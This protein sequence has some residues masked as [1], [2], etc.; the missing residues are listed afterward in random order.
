M[1]Y[2]S[3]LYEDFFYTNI[4]SGLTAE[5]M[6]FANYLTAAVISAEMMDFCNFI[7]MTLSA[8]MMDTLGVAIIIEGYDLSTGQKKFVSPADNVL[9][10][11]GS[12]LSGTG[13]T[14]ATGLGG[15]TGL[16]G[17]QGSTG[18]TGSTGLQGITGFSVIGSTGNQGIT[19]F[20]PQG[21]TG[22]QGAT[23]II[24]ITGFVGVTGI[25]Q[26][27]ATG[28]QGTTG[29]IGITGIAPAGPDGLQGETG[30]LDGT[31]TGVQ[32][33]TGIAPAGLSPQGATGVVQGATGVQGNTGI[34]PRGVAGPAQTLSAQ[35]QASGTSFSYSIP[36]N[37]LTVNEQ[38][39]EFIVWGT[40]ATGGFQTPT[41][42]TVTFGSTTI[43]TTTMQQDAATG[44]FLARGI[45]LR[46]G[47]SAEEIIVGQVNSSDSDNMWV[48]RT[49]ATE[50]LGNALTLQVSVSSSG[51]GHAVRALVVRKVLQA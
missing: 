4:Q 1:G 40:C 12:F 29:F 25:S 17:T 51:T 8:E 2:I 6:D 38:Y 37:T 33:I 21:E 16:Q 23:G 14:G 7:G 31:A 11:N 9:R 32:G 41:T 39:V 26:R 49:S 22:L 30:L 47:A 10:S 15:S 50:N 18:L 27:G 20:S 36:A 13:I 5:M 34:A 45:I 46:T 42:L 28:V 44:A 35:T 3:P 24:G 43:L 19:G 48:D